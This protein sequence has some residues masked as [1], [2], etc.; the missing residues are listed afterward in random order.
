MSG[1]GAVV[2]AR[3]LCHGTQSALEQSWS[4]Q[5]FHTPSMCP[6]I[7]I[8]RDMQVHLYMSVSICIDIYAYMYSYIFIGKVHV[9]YT[10]YACMHMYMY[11]GFCAVLSEKQNIKKEK[12]M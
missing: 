1:L 8:G 11:L 7:W 12:K 10:L 6:C 4:S 3:S 2:R 5:S 9:E